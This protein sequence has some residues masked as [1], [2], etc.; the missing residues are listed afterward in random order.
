MVWID[1]RGKLNFEIEVDSHSLIYI[2]CLK[3]AH[4]ITEIHIYNISQVD[5]YQMR[6]YMLTVCQSKA[7]LYEDFKL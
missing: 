1:N 4:T 2:M 7:C 5:N 6:T 3:S